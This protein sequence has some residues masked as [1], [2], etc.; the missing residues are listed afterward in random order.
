MTAHSK[1]AFLYEQIKLSLQSGGYVPGERI[2][3]AAIAQH[4][5]TSQTPVRF[6]L[7]RLVGEGMLDDH[8]REGLHVPLPTEIALRDLYDW[9]QRL[10]SMACDMGFPSC[11][12]ATEPFGTPKPEDDLVQSTQRL[13]D[14]IAMA[15]GH[16]AL[17]RAVQMTNGRLA[18]LRHAKQGLLK[19]SFDELSM[20]GKH[21]DERDIPA[22]RLAL[23]EYHERRKL[24]VPQIV[25]VLTNK[26]PYNRH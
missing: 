7:Y 26:S 17:H 8:A 14:D 23:T 1:G 5:H 6:A 18:P 11:A 13:F 21:W 22:L 19:H 9:M 25:S 20:L 12:E 10:L 16:F 2:D 3:P 4:F 15:T 24:L